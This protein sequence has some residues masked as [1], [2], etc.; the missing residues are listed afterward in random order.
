ML[1]RS[2]PTEA[3][4]A[5]PAPT[6]QALPTDPIWRHKSAVWLKNIILMLIL[7]L[8][9]TLI[10]WWRIVKIKPGRRR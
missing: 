4:A 3:R 10:A 1:F 6:V 8:A 5:A 9:F 7:G 2:K